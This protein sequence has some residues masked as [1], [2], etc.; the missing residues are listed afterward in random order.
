MPRP[1]RQPTSA[2]YLPPLRSGVVPVCRR[3]L[4]VFSYQL[5]KY[6]GTDFK[7]VPALLPAPVHVEPICDMMYN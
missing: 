6:A 1:I 4:Q 5:N 2:L 3:A 7:F